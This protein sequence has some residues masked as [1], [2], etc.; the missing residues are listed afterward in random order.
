[1]GTGISSA[2]RRADPP[3]VAIATRQT[4]LSALRPSQVPSRYRVR[5]STAAFISYAQNGEDVV[6][7]RALGTITEGRYVDVGANDPVA[8]SVT[9]A[10]YQ[11]GWSGITID[12]VHDYAEKQRLMRPRDIMIEAAVSGESGTV[13]LHQIADTGLST[14]MDD[15]GED[16]RAAGWAVE[17]VTV[18]ARRLD[19]ILSDAGW[20]DNDIHFM[21][22]DTEGSERD[23]L[24][25]VDLRKWRPWV[26][27]VEATRPQTTEPTHESWESL[28]LEARYRFC[29]FDG[30]S[31]FY[32][33]EEKLDQLA[34]LLSAPANILDG[35]RTY[36]G[37]LREQ[38]IQRLHQT[39]ADLAAARDGLAVER[40]RLN[41][42]RDRA[43]EDARQRDQ[44]NLRNH[45]VALH[46]HQGVGAGSPCPEQRDAASTDGTAHQSHQVR[47]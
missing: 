28:V 17:E 12:P 9:F 45:P 10:F 13:T 46:R 33:A 7:H 35:Y 8:D 30:L 27:V 25:T 40:D 32:V 22:V 18:P 6:L 41:H 36:Q 19:D 16:H 3:G 37:E 15:V 1:M 24:G 21:V 43:K 39:L 31:R 38:E 23:V 29:L 34:A 4:G 26:L 11:R 20:Q 5:V 14:L 42:E 47:R 44:Q 2:N